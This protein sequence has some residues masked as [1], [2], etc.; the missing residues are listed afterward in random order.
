MRAGTT[1][2]L[3]DMRAVAGAMAGATVGLIFWMW[4]ALDDPAYYAV[5]EVRTPDLDGLN[6]MRARRAA[7][8]VE[9]R[10][11]ERVDALSA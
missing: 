4:K 9:A 11:K 8:I 3:S 7:Q 6:L 1:A 10:P 5:P 2:T